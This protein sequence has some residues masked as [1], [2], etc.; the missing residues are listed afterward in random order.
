M[1]S[2]GRAR[3]VLGIS[4]PQRG[5]RAPSLAGAFILTANFPAH[6][7]EHAAKC[8][9][10]YLGSGLFP[11]QRLI[12]FAGEAR[13]LRFLGGVAERR[14]GTALGAVRRRFGVAASWRADLMFATCF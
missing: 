6:V 10:E 13:D 3:T 5:Q 4:L 2:N 8:N 1:H 11:L 12:A 7:R 14:L 9:A